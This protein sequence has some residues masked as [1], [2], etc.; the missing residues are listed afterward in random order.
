MSH[1]EAGTATRPG[2]AGTRKQ[3]NAVNWRH[4]LG[5]S[6]DTQETTGVEYRDRWDMF[7][8]YAVPSMPNFWV[9]PSATSRA[10]NF[11]TVASR[12]RLTSKT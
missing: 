9:L 10:L 8:L 11:S 3:Q 1:V 6:Q 2:W 12:R 5:Q 7:T 4:R